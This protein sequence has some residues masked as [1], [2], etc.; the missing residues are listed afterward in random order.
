MTDQLQYFVNL[1]WSLFIFY[2][3]VKYFVH[4]MRLMQKRYLLAN[5]YINF[6][7]QAAY[8][9]YTFKFFLSVNMWAEIHLP[10][11]ITLWSR[12]SVQAGFWKRLTQ[13]NEKWSVFSYTNKW[14]KVIDL[15]DS[16]CKN[17][18]LVF[19]RSRIFLHLKKL[20]VKLSWFGYFVSTRSLWT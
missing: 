8:F 17:L 3:V 5:F 1:V 9:E 6:N 16:S 14:K 15:I 4:F 12:K 18:V 19:F 7:M 2:F 11:K 10:T 20:T 13:K